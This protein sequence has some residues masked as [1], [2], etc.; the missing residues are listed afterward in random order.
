MAMIPSYQDMLAQAL[1]QQPQQQQSMGQSQQSKSIFNN[2]AFGNSLM[3]MGLT[4]L[5][6]SEQGYSLGESIG[7]GGLAFMDE[8]QKQEELQRKEQRQNAFLAREQLQD[9]LQKMALQR[10]A[11]QYDAAAQQAQGLPQ[12]YQG[13]ASIDPMMALKQ[14]MTDRINAQD[15]ERTFA[16]QVQLQNMQYGNQRAL[17]DSQFGNQVSLAEIQGQNQLALENLKLTTGKKAAASED[18]RKAVTWLSQAT[19]SYQNMLNSMYDKNGNPTG[20]ESPYLI[21]VGPLDPNVQKFKQAT[22]SLAESLLRASTGAGVTKDEAAQKIRE[23]TPSFY[24]SAEVKKQKLDS[25]PV[26]IESLKL[27]AGRALP[28]AVFETPTVQGPSISRGASVKLPDGR[29][30]NF[31]SQEAADS[32]KREAGIQ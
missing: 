1:Q 6:D 4:M 15:A 28:E 3:K 8:R 18:E 10:E 17:Q 32:F 25:I 16:Q 21:N 7:R 5:T 2:P 14:Q 30:M 24:D 29:L 11:M 27:R 20:A 19:N 13:I 9:N 12:D 22:S 26:Y 23:I 31:P